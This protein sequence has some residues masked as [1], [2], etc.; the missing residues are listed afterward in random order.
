MSQQAVSFVVEWLLT[1][2]DF[3]TQFAIERLETLLGIQSE[4][5]DL[6]NDETVAFAQTDIRMWCWPEESLSLAAFS[7]CRTWVES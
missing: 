3:R 1:D 4:A 7:R 5:F 6:T 2:P